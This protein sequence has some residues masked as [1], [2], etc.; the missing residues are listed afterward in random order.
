MM[1]EDIKSFEIKLE[2]VAMEAI[3]FKEKVNERM[4]FNDKLYSEMKE[5]LKKYYQELHQMLKEK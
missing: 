4:I 2:D 3:N 5:K 1:K